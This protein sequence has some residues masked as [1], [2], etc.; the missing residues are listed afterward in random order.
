MKNGTIVT[1]PLGNGV[2][3]GEESFYNRK[4]LR[5]LVKLDWVKV[6]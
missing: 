6:T 4:L 1:T 5:Y 3:V 2:I